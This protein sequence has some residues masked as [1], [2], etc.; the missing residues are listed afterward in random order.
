MIIGSCL[1]KVIWIKI[2]LISYECDAY[3]AIVWTMMLVS[4]KGQLFPKSYSRY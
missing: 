1:L 3:L 2:I 4:Q